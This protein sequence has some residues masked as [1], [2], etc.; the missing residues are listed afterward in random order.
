VRIRRQPTSGEWDDLLFGWKIVRGVTSISV[1]YVKE[2]VTVGIGAGQQDRISAAQNARDKAY[3]KLVDRLAWERFRCPFNQIE[4]ADMRDSIRADA[5]ELHGGLIGAAMAS[6]GPFIFFDPIDM[7]ISE[8]VTAIIQ[9]GG[10]ALDYDIIRL[11]NE[12]NVTMVI[13]GQRV[14]KY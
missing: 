12:H 9:P 6:D 1:I 11:C 14:Y 3:R 8:G 10:S 4:N 13:T 2:G 5:D 7:S